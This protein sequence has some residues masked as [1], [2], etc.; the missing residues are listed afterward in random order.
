VLL[1]IGLCPVYKALLDM[2]G[3]TKVDIEKYQTCLSSALSNVNIPH[4]ALGCSMYCTDVS[5]LSDIDKYYA[6]IVSCIVT[7]TN[8]CVTVH[9]SRLNIHN[10]PGWSDFVK[11]KQDLARD[12]FLEWV[13]V[14]KPRS[15]PILHQLMSYTHRV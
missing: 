11:E 9:E 2:I 5:H 8:L 15:G 3:L 12:V 13:A 1:L 10:V 14:G 7:T 6:D 4:C